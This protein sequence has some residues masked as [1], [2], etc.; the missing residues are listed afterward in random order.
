MVNYLQKHQIMVLYKWKTASRYLKLKNISFFL[1]QNSHLI[2]T[3]IHIKKKKQNYY[4]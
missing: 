2:P 3:H 1:E 4:I